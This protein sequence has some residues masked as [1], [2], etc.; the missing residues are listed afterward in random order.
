MQE[1]AKPKKLT[2]AVVAACPF[3]YPRGTPTRI[4]RL[5]EALAAVGNDVHVITYHLGTEYTPPLKNLFVHRIDNVPS[6]Q[7]L[8]PGPS[9]KK[10]FVLDAMLIGKLREVL[11]DVS[12]DVI[13]GHHYEGLL[14][15]RLARRG[16][17]IPIVYDAHTMLAT[18]L[19]YYGSRIPN[20]LKSAF[21]S[22]LDRRIPGAADGI[23][24]VTENIERSLAPLAR[25]P[26][27]I[28]TIPNGVELD[29]F[30]VRRRPIAHPAPPEGSTKTVLYSG[31][32]ADYQRIDLLLRSFAVIAR[33]RDDIAFQIVT[34]GDFIPFEALSRE[35]GVF[36]RIEIVHASLRE[37]AG[38]IANADVAVNP[39]IDCAGLPQKNLNYLAAGVPIVCF[40]GSA[41]QLTDGLTAYIVP[42]GDVGEFADAI[43][44]AID[45]PDEAHEMGVRGRAYVEDN[46]SWDLAAQTTDLFFQYLVK[47]HVR[48]TQE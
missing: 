48:S 27:R 1:E 23:I 11:R 31:T 14:A 33:K 9:W 12:V 21:G 47:D 35:L 41:K 3:P 22:A 25:S 40:A 17:D 24:C 43:C 19:P 29:V 34:D 37:L 26:E 44:R 18:E 16:S 4:L 30:S 2:V 38:L 28:I 46:C 45:Q 5:S 13:H 20:A 36:E 6:Y 15:A 10:L 39:R 7:K 32:L 42:D 8:D